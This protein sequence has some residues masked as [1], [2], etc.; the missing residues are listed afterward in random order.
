MA[1]NV[2][3]RPEDVASWMTRLRTAMFENVTEQDVAEI[4]QAL[5]R[6]AKEGDLAATRL[7]FNYVLGSSTVNVK[8]AVILQDRPLAP[9]P[10]PA[11]VAMP[12]TREKLEV[13]AKRAAAGLPL[14]DPRDRI[15]R[16]G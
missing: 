4:A 11:T 13:M 7:L 15:Y 9:L 12:Q 10:A 3:P 1:K 2:A 8:Q 6:K 14:C 5:V 16:E